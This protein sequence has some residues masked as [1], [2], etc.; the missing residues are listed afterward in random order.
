M[1]ITSKR[2]DK[3]KK[4]KNQSK[5]R[6]HYK[7]KKKNGKEKNRRK[8]RK[9]N[10]ST[11]I[12]RKTHK[13]KKRA[14]DLKNKS[15]KFK[16]NQPGKKPAPLKIITTDKPVE[17]VQTGGAPIVPVVKNN[18]KTLIERAKNAITGYHK[19]Q[20]SKIDELKDDIYGKITK[21]NQFK[22]LFL[23]LKTAY[24]G[25][26]KAEA[27]S[28][29][30]A[31]QIAQMIADKWYINAKS[32]TDNKAG[33][34]K[35]VINK[36]IDEF[37]T[38][39]VGEDAIYER[40]IDIKQKFLLMIKK[41]QYNYNNDYFST[42]DENDEN[43][44][45]IMRLYK[46]L[47]RY[48][49]QSLIKKSIGWSDPWNRKFIG[50]FEE[51]IKSLKQTLTQAEKNAANKQKKEAERAKNEQR[52]KYIEANILTD[53]FKAFL[54]KVKGDEVKE[55]EVKDDSPYS[56]MD[57]EFKTLIKS[58][59]IRNP[60]QADFFNFRTNGENKATEIYDYLMDK[61]KQDNIR[62]ALTDDKDELENFNAMIKSIKFAEF[63]NITYAQP[64]NENKHQP[65]IFLLKQD[66]S[67]DQA[68]IPIDTSMP[69]A[70]DVFG[71]FGDLGD[72]TKHVEVTNNVVNDESPQSGGEQEIYD[73]IL[74]YNTKKTADQWKDENWIKLG[75]KLAGL[76]TGPD[77]TQFSEDLK[78]DKFGEA[79]QVVTAMGKVLEKI[80]RENVMTVGVAYANKTNLGDEIARV[81]PDMNGL[82]LKAIIR[83][84]KAFD[85]KS[86]LRTP[87]GTR[88]IHH[89]DSF[90]KLD[91]GDHQYVH[92]DAIKN[93]TKTDGDNAT[94]I[95]VDIKESLPDATSCN[96]LIFLFNN[97]DKYPKTADL[98]ELQ[99]T[100]KDNG[101]NRCWIN[102][103]LYAVLFGIMNK[104]G[105]LS[106]KKRIEGGS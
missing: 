87:D 47:M 90:V 23:I 2:L 5:R 62:K 32:D 49:I 69:T 58:V 29:Q 8:N 57:A 40:L 53:E 17:T 9:Y 10:K 56:N 66:T 102:A 1:N 14:Y 97:N 12:Y 41:I 103:T 67:D 99:V 104:K 26:E 25:L 77:K 98:K 18:L 11:G 91:D 7:N 22:A 81:I 34:V 55:E 43:K 27:T 72:F 80:A 83:G 45:N 100:T 68:F 78:N 51:I 21:D 93:G 106:D 79:L 54:K 64:K 85:C 94:P 13:Q 76:I 38:M 88:S 95:V 16:D 39:S 31:D 70:T 82:H 35:T 75:K 101:T 48:E 3:I 20:D 19:K 65:S 44:T 73:M 92:F 50:V 28:D 52:A 89:Y 61:T 74:K 4:T 6:I 60:G 71:D 63:A 36:L 105:K 42:G 96:Y 30:T 46:L 15:L 37:A 86:D 59:V 33:N 24:D 84:T